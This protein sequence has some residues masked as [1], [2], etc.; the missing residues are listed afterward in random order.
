MNTKKVAVLGALGKVG[1]V[2]CDAVSADPE[3]ELKACIDNADSADNH[4]HKIYSSLD[5]ALQSAGDIDVAVDF[6]VASATE[7]NLK[8]LGK[9]G[10]HAVVGT[11]GIPTKTIDSLEGVFK[12][13]NCL[14]ASNFSISAVMMMRLSEIAAPFFESAEIIEMHHDQKIDAPSGT[15]LETL[16]RIERANNSWAPDPTQKENLKGVRGGVGAS[17]VRIHSLRMKGALAHQ[18]VRFGALGQGLTIRQDSFNR[19][20]FVPGVLL[21]LKTIDEYPGIT[22]GLDKF[23]GL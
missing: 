21:A 8:V 16:E 18:E 7:K 13:S 20:S 6:T 12:N 2:I 1:N 19:D 4:K 15:A 23:L 22:L 9:N 5:E 11:S 10:I 17:G 14:I 3:L